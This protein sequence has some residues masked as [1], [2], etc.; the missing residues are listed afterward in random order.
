MCLLP[1]AVLVG[2]KGFEIL[3]S[4]FGLPIYVPA[5]IGIGEITGGEDEVVGSCDDLLRGVGHFSGIGK[6]DDRFNLVVDFSNIY[7]RCT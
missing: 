2:K 4:F 1:V 7:S 3:T 6:I 5:M